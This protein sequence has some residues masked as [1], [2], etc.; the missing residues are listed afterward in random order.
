MSLKRKTPTRPGPSRPR[1][2]VAA[3]RVPASDEQR[4]KVM[5]TGCLVCG[6]SPVDPAHVV[7][8]GGS[9]TPPEAP[10]VWFGRSP[11]A[12]ASRS[13]P[14]L[15]TRATVD[16]RHHVVDVETCE[17]ITSAPPFQA[18]SLVA[19]SSNGAAARISTPEARATVAAVD[20]SSSYQGFENPRMSGSV[21]MTSR[22]RRG[23]ALC[24]RHRTGASAASCRPRPHSYS[25]SR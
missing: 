13:G 20:I 23:S 17:Q 14:P 18:Q 6:R 4:R 8:H 10:S 22:T 5:C 12:P 21:G 2:V 16:Q 1:A 24:H 25:P 15:A 7:P 11:E 3:P 19:T 9:R